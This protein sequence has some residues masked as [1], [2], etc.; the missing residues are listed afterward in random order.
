M[1]WYLLHK[2]SVQMIEKIISE[3]MYSGMQGGMSG[4]VQPRNG[5][6]QKNMG[7]AERDTY[8]EGRGMS[9]RVRMVK[10]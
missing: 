8:A 6:C 10:A 2:R 3:G 4:W 5:D 9:R 7:K 1:G